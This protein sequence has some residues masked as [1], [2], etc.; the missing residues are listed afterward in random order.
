MAQL[1]LNTSKPV[2][3]IIPE[4]IRRDD[5]LEE[6]SRTID[7]VRRSPKEGSEPLVKEPGPE[8]GAGGSNFFGVAMLVL[9][10]I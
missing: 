7:L 6:S 2:S 4:L 5:P 10:K 9:S 1:A 3:E 8:A